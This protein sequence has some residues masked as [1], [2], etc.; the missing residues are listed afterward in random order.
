MNRDLHEQSGSSCRQRPGSGPTGP[1]GY[2]A[3][4]AWA[5]WPIEELPQP[6]NGVGGPGGH[7]WETLVTKVR[8]SK[9][10]G[11]LVARR[12][13]LCNHAIRD[14]ISHPPGPANGPRAMG[15]GQ[16]GKWASGQ[17]GKWA[18]GQVG[19]WA[20]GKWAKHEGMPASLF[21]SKG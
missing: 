1:C 18:S 4:T 7:E 14:R 15:N 19:K 21:R 13:P 17:V 10:L 6:R 20:S 12:S 8:Y 11:R 9:C 2:G 16:M 3:D 5:H